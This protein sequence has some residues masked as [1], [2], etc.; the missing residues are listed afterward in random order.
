MESKAI[1]E[2]LKNN[3]H[4]LMDE[5]RLLQEVNKEKELEIANLQRLLKEK[6]TE[7]AEINEKYRVLKMAKSLEGASEENRDVKLKINEMVREID[8]CIALL[9]R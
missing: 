4:R 8:K 2:S 6:E 5:F 1:I 3:V 9:N 7:N